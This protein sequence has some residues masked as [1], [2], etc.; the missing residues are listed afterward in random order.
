M[1]AII[2]SV[3]LL[4]IVKLLSIILDVLMLNVI[5]S[6]FMLS[7]VTLFQRFSSSCNLINNWIQPE[8]KFSIGFKNST[9]LSVMKKTSQLKFKNDN[10]WHRLNRSRTDRFITNKFSCHERICSLPNLYLLSL[11]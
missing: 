2:L 1:N 4:N 8:L 10:P 3:I 7:V 6:V 11:F 5:L 9:I